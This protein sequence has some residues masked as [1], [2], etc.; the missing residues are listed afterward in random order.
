MAGSKKEIGTGFITEVDRY[1]F[2]NGRHY[3]IFEKMGAHPKT[4]CILPS[5]HL[6]RSR[7]VSSAT[8]TV[9]TRRQMR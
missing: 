1:L 3:E 4:A 7:S 5:G 9:G 8:L 6:M 2:N